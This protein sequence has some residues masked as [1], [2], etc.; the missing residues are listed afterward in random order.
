L[1]KKGII[2]YNDTI[3]G[4]FISWKFIFVRLEFDNNIYIHLFKLNSQIWTDSNIQLV[5]HSK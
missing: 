1:Y 3:N 2:W 5:W 4:K